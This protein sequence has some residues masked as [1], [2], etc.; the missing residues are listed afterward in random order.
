MMQGF[1]ET[2]LMEFQGGQGRARRKARRTREDSTDDELV[3]DS[4]NAASIVSRL[5]RGVQ[6][7]LAVFQSEAAVQAV[8]ACAAITTQTNF[9]ATL[10]EAE[11]QVNV[12][13]AAMSTQTGFSASLN[14]AK[15]QA[16]VACAAKTTQTDPC[17]YSAALAGSGGVRGRGGAETCQQSNVTSNMASQDDDTL[18]FDPWA[19]VRG[20]SRDPARRPFDPWAAVRGTSKDPAL[21]RKRGRGKR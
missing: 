21:R 5:G 4:T 14:D 9:S 13:C 2:S 18:P 17:P 7:D 6:T 12:A 19:A 16:N 10:T 8:D 3:P 1:P 11:V 15:V 20:T